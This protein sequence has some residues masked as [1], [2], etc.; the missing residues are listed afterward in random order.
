MRTVIQPVLWPKKIFFNYK[1]ISVSQKAI[2]VKI[3][4]FSEKRYQEVQN[5]IQKLL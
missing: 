2:P 3:S 5:L 1:E 4:P